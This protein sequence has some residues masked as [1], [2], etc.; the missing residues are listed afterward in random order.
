VTRFISTSCF[1]VDGPLSLSYSLTFGDTWH[2]PVGRAAPV[3]ARF[4]SN[5]AVGYH[6]PFV[7]RNFSVEFY[8]VSPLPSPS[9]FS[10]AGCRIHLSNFSGF[11]RVSRLI[12]TVVPSVDPPLDF[13]LPYSVVHYHRRGPSTPSKIVRPSSNNRYRGFPPLSVSFLSFLT[14]RYYKKAPSLAA[15]TWELMRSL[16]SFAEVF[17]QHELGWGNGPGFQGVWFGLSEFPSIPGVF[18]V[19][20]TLLGMAPHLPQVDFLVCFERLRIASPFF[21][22]FNWKKRLALTVIKR[23]ITPFMSNGVPLF[24]FSGFLLL[25]GQGLFGSLFFILRVIR[26]LCVCSA[27]MSRKSR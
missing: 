18:L 11:P 25:K 21:F 26:D 4:V 6:R 22:F 17:R 14:K 5:R 15:F 9:C 3:L 23:L 12:G 13:L 19:G 20:A 10:S 27:R 7:G 2:R 24:L 16:F 8:S 1:Q